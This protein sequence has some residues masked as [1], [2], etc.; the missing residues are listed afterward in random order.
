MAY[1]NWNNSNSHL[2][3]LIRPQNGELHEASGDVDFALK[4]DG[5]QK[6]AI[7]NSTTN[8]WQH[9]TL[10][11]D[12]VWH[13]PVNTTDAHA[14]DK[15]VVVAQF[16]AAAGGAGSVDYLLEYNV[17]RRDEKCKNINYAVTVKYITIDLNWIKFI[18]HKTHQVQWSKLQVEWV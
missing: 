6:V 9:L 17:I 16:S 7:I 15:L 1:D 2:N 18:L 12:G 5:A 13:G 14:G 11:A 8:E 10:S 3:K 4:V